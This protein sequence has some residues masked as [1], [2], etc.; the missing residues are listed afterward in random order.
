MAHPTLL[1]LV[2]FKTILAESEIM[3]IAKARAEE[4]RALQGLVQKYYVFDADTGEY[5]GVYLW[6]SAEALED[7]RRSELRASIAAAYQVEGEA[8]LDVLKVLMPLRE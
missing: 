7:Y 4:F 8:R 2:R 3:E 6:E 5:G 1:L